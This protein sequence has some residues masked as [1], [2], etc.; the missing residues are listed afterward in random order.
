MDGGRGGRA[1]ENKVGAGA[2]AQQNRPRR[3][4]S[5][6]AVHPNWAV[7][8]VPTKH[9]KIASPAD[10]DADEPPNRESHPGGQ[11]AE[12]KLPCARKKGGAPGEDRDRRADDEESHRA[13]G[14]ACQDRRV[15]PKKEEGPDG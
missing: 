8:A 2:A 7:A 3:N 9:R 11:E 1:E 6:R 5:K 14:D 15:A 4:K 12:P 13:G 10:G